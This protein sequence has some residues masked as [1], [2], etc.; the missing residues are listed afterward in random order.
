MTPPN[1]N[2]RPVQARIDLAALQHNLQVVRNLSASPVMAIIKADGYGHGMEQVADALSGADQFGVSGLD[3]ARRLRGHGVSLPLTLLS[4]NFDRA[5]LDELQQLEARPVIYDAAHLPL[6]NDWS[7]TKPLNVWLKLDAGMGRLGFLPQAVTG[8]ARRLADMSGI[9]SVSLMAHF[10]NADH[11]RHPGTAL[12]LELFEQ[13]A[14]EFDYAELSV[15]NSGAVV[16]GIGLDHTV[17]P[18][19]ML[20]GISPLIE[21]S[22]AELNLRAAMTFSSQLISVRSLSSGTAVGYGGTHVLARE[23]RIGIVA[24]G[25]GD[26]YPRHAISG[27]PV[28]VNGEIAP[29]IGRVSMDMLAVDLG[30]QPAEVGDKVVL[31]GPDNPVEKIAECAST[32][33]YE[34]VCG[35]TNRVPRTYQ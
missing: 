16:T 6:L 29:L 32:I 33:A 24:C 34:L 9:G 21:A 26:G 19:I 2:H 4:A 23:S 12:Q 30:D 11:P 10:A 18:G 27:T 8:V 35:V 15:A 31:W 22:A 25:Y 5:G 1:N 7:P 17:R 14:G 3:D 28:L 20:Y 13:L